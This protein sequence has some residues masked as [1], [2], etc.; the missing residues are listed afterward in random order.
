MNSPRLPTTS[1]PSVEDFL[2]PY[3]ELSRTTDE[4]VSVHISTK[5]SETMNSA[6]QAREQFKRH[7]RIE[8]VDSQT[9]SLGLGIVAM[10]ANLA[11]MRWDNW[12][13]ATAP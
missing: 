7:C 10:A 12:E 4:I 13:E 3:Q 1:Q 6:N 2:Q 8:T 5:L 9:G 11:T